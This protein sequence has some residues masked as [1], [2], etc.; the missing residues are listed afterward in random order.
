MI[1]TLREQDLRCANTFFQKP[2]KKK[3]TFEQVGAGPEAGPW[4]P[5]RYAEIDYCL[6]FGRCIKTIN[7]VEVDTDTNV[8][9]DH[10]S[11][12]VTVKQQLKAISKN[13]G[14]RS[15]QGATATEQQK[16]SYY[17]YKKD[18]IGPDADTVGMDD[19]MKHLAESAE[20]NLTLKG[21]KG[22]GKTA[23][24]C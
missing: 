12:I 24:L 3:G 5:N 6:V 8:N 7:N 23:T 19:L 14:L 17:Q 4:T 2:A 15:L 11:L 20:K 10:R 21:A 22:K 18:L 9:T 16:E 13:G 1:D